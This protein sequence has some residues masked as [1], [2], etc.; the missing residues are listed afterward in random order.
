MQDIIANKREGGAHSPAEIAFIVRAAA[1]GSVPDYQLSAWLMAVFL[2]GMDPAETVALTGAMAR[3]GRR[4]KPGRGRGPVVDKHS[5]G[6]VGDGISLA[7]APAAAAAGCAVPMMSGRGLGHTGGTLDKL[8]S[9]RG[10]RVRMGAPAVERQVRR[11]GLAMFGAG[12]DLA[13][14]DGRLYS[15]RDATATVECLPLVV[16]SI[17]SKKLAEGLGAL[18]LDIKCGSGA[19]FAN[20]HQAAKLADA[21]IGTSRRLGLRCGGILSDMDQ[22]LGRAVGNGLEMKQAIEILHGDFSCSDYLEVLVTLGGLMLSLSRKARNWREG[23]EKI[24]SALRS[25]R[26][27]AVF[28]KM[29]RAQG[30]DT[31]A[32]DDPGRYFKP[33]RLS[34]ALKARRAGK[35]TRFDAKT[36]GQAAVLLGAGRANMEDRVDFGAGILISRKVGDRV[37]PG[38]ELARVYASDA[39]RLSAGFRLLSEGVSVGRRPPRRRKIIRKIWK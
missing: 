3:S 24:E 31:R 7:L 19:F 27:L 39:G 11:I 12:G 35:V 30:G 8:E 15:L 37:R 14:A 20:P 32:V 29:V 34:R 36:A 13:P 16:A 26:A 9:I 25:G 33:A 2:R 6:G 5:T 23:A 28:K 17:L 18:V 38:T 1:E 10:L 21:L 4:L 22:P